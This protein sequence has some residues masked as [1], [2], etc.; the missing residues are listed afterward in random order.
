MFLG[1]SV[2][3]LLSLPIDQHFFCEHENHCLFLGADIDCDRDLVI[4]GAAVV[5]LPAFTVHS[6]K[7]S[8]RT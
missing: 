5:L 1:S 2:D 8:Q 7:T 4:P 6:L 3:P